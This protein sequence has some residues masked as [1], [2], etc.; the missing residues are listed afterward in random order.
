LV[1]AARFDMRRCIVKQRGDG[2]GLRV[3][4]AYLFVVIMNQG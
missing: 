4:D 3:C 2:S 1:T